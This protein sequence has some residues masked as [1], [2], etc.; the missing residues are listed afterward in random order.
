[1]VFR[2]SGLSVCVG[3]LAPYSYGL[4]L[5]GATRHFA[6]I[7]RSRRVETRP[8]KNTTQQAVWNRPKEINFQTLITIIYF[9]F[10]N[11]E[12]IKSAQLY[13]C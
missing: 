3:A 9:T 11:E 6:L 7:Y 8:T 4:P 12:N 13:F 10:H 1:M 5:A 2:R